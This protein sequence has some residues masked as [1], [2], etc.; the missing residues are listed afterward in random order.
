MHR[1]GNPVRISIASLL[2]VLSWTGAPQHAFAQG[3]V[4]DLPDHYGPG[5]SITVSIAIN[6]PEG[7]S[8]AIPEDAPPAGWSVSDISNGGTWDAEQQKVKWGPFFAPSIPALVTYDAMP[9]GDTRGEQC[10][11]GTI[12]FEPPGEEEP[13]AGDPCIPVA[14][15][16]LSEWGMMVL[17]L[18]I[19]VSGT[20]AIDR[21]RHRSANASR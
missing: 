7:V 6:P 14:V 11:A 9:P 16:T 18:L 3:A 17:L 21:V 19:L 20:L 15:P 1:N 10:F 12:F 13:V 8:F 4:R 2:A 5:V